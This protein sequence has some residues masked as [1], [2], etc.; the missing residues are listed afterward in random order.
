MTLAIK[1]A[2]SFW[3]RYPWVSTA[4]G[5]AP[6]AIGLIAFLVL[7]I[8]LMVVSSFQTE[9]GWSLSN[10]FDTVRGEYLRAFAT[11]LEISLVTAIVGGVLGT[12]TAIALAWGTSNLNNGLLTLA[13]VAANWGGVPLAFAMIATV[14]N[15]GWITELLRSIGF[16]LYKQG[17]TIYGNLGLILTYTYF[18]WPLMLLLMLPAVQRFRQQWREASESLGATRSQFWRWVAIPIL[19]PS[20]I[21]GMALLFANAFGAQATAFALAGGALN[22]ITIKITFLVKGQTDFNPGLANALAV[23]MTVVLAIAV[24]IYQSTNQRARRWMK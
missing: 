1:P 4:L 8:L 21:G 10:Y 17:F 11:T 9:Q 7:P 12:L 15:S 5:L 22:L 16:D 2:R 3:V 19:A 23:E 24:I 18:Q 14:G 13:S 6:M 20:M